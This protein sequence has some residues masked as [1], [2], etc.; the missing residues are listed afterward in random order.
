MRDER[1][2]CYW[3]FKKANLKSKLLSNIEFSTVKRLFKDLICFHKVTAENP[4]YNMQGLIWNVFCKKNKTKKAIFNQ[5]KLWYKDELNE[6]TFIVLYFEHLN[7]KC[8]KLPCFGDETL[9]IK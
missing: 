3:T 8:E 5:K 7:W 6:V 1:S 9:E 4:L 2:V